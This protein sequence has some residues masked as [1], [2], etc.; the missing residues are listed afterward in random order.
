MAIIL[1]F[2]EYDKAKEIVKDYELYDIEL[3]G[4]KYAIIECDYDIA[5]GKPIT[6]GHL[7]FDEKTLNQL[8]SLAETEY[9]VY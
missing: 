5:S 4:K 2:V 1:Y 6:K 7:E 9:V 3:G 8:I